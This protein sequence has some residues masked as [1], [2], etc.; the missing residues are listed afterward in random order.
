MQAWLRGLAIAS[1]LLLATCDDDDGGV[2]IAV[3]TG[4]L[5][6]VF[7]DCPDCQETVTLKAYGRYPLR[8]TDASVAGQLAARCGFT[9]V[10]DPTSTHVQGCA[11]GLDLAF[12][13]GDLQAFRVRSGWGGRTDRGI[14][15]GASMQDVLAAEPGFARVDERTLLLDDGDRRAEASFASDERLVELIVGRG[16]RR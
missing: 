12:I 4:G 13:G 3:N 14:A 11:S 10:R 6:V 7:V 1:A 16:F 15:I 9:A 5:R 8:G 2:L